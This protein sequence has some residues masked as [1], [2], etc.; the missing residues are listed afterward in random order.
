MVDSAPMSEFTCL[1]YHE[2]S[3]WNSSARSLLLRKS[4][5]TQVMKSTTRLGPDKYEFG[6]YEIPPVPRPGIYEF[7]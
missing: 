2:V 3:A 1:C 4:P 7:L 5:G 6:P